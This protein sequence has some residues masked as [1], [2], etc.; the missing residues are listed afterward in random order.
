MNKKI[1]S[2]A[3]FVFVMLG[4]WLFFRKPHITTPV[5]QENIG[6]TTHSI[7]SGTPLVTE[8]SIT[9]TIQDRSGA[10]Q[11]LKA[12]NKTGLTNLPSM[13]TIKLIDGIRV[14]EPLLLLSESRSHELF[15]LEEKTQALT[16]IPTLS[17]LLIGEAGTELFY[18][19]STRF[20]P[21][22]G[23]VTDLNVIRAYDLKTGLERTL[24][25]LPDEQSYTQKVSGILTIP[26]GTASIQNNIIR[27][28]VY[29]VTPYIYEG[30]TRLPI[31]I[32][33]I[34]IDPSLPKTDLTR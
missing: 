1:A 12:I 23:R 10:N 3:V 6:N 24:E 4:A 26:S 8:P 11:T 33:T 18:F 13:K 17:E 29:S 32:H 21:I 30:Q 7:N 27:A 19:A 5:T 22:S 34:R 14:L 20:V 2:G 28:E 16:R 31:G 15:S 9:I 25:S